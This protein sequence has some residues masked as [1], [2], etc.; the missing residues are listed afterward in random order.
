MTAL[1]KVGASL[2]LVAG[3][4]VGLAGSASAT[5]EA[6]YRWGSFQG[7]AHEA[8]TPTVVRDL[9]GVTAIAAGN[10]SDMALADGKVY[11]F[12]NGAFGNLGHGPGDA[13]QATA[14]KVR[15]LP[16]IVAIG[17]SMDTDVAIADDGTVWGWGWNRGGQLCTGNTHEYDRP[18]QLTN[19]SDIEAAAGGYRHMVYLTT[20]GTVETCGENTSG[21]LGDGS[22]ASSTVPVS[23]D[24]P[25]TATAVT[26]GQ[27]SAAALLANGTV[28]DWGRDKFG[29]LGNGDTTSSD[30]PVEVELP[31][32]AAE[33]SVGGSAPDNGQALALLE[34]GQIWGWGC[35]SDGQLGDGKTKRVRD[36]P[37]EAKSLPSDVTF[38]AV[39]S[40]GAHGLA[41][42]SNG[43]VWGWGD[44]ANGQV[45]NGS[46]GGDVLTPVEV[47]SGADL[48]SS[49]AG[50]SEAHVPAA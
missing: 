10:L 16:P 7:A 20:S 5:A 44:N 1:R 26:A 23:V 42:D 45:G 41:L 30:V 24:L 25:D 12:G 35:D 34:N 13:Y 18:V 15:G 28:Y 9:T 46:S 19:L 38:T 4:T 31:S 14:Q 49:T 27:A 50:D 36:V 37:V 32:A 11:T 40:G 39:V 8:T 48:I 21:V 3:L 2:A 29:E 6:T 47:L 43:N 33:V 17:E 22:E